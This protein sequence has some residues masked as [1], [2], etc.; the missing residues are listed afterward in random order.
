[1]VKRQQ[2]LFRA[3]HLVCIQ[4]VGIPSLAQFQNRPTYDTTMTAGIRYRAELSGVVS[5]NGRSPF[6]MRSN[7]FGTVPWQ[8]PAGIGTVGVTGLWG[9][10]RQ[11]HKPYL[12]AGIEVV[13]NLNS[14]S[15][16]VLP[17][18]YVAVRLGHGELYIGRQKEIHGLV[19]T[20]LTSGSIAWSG[21]A[22]PITQIR[23]G[24]RDFAP[25]K[26]TKGLIAVNAFF[27]HGWFSDTDS[28]HNVMLHA[29]AVFVRVGK[30]T[31]KVRFY[32][33][34]NHFAQWGGYSKALADGPV[35]KFLSANGYLPSSLKAYKSVVWPIGQP[36]SDDQFSAIDTIN[37]IGNHLGSI[38]AG[39]DI[40][41]KNASLFLYSQHIFE[42]N[43]GLTFKNFPDGLFGVRWKAGVSN[44]GAV[45][46]LKQLTA[47]FITTRNRSGTKLP[48][49]RDDYFFHG[50]YLDGWTHQGAIIGTP[51]FTRTADLP[52]AL[53]KKSA[54]LSR[55]FAY[56][57]LPVNNNDVQSVHV[58]AYAVLFQ[59]VSA[60][61]LAT[62]SRYYEFDYSART[63]DQLSMSLE[64]T[65]LVLSGSV[66]MGLKLAYDTG[67]IFTGNLGGMLTIRKTGFLTQKPVNR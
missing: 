60:V 30:P 50:Q 44:S 9:N 14:A 65:N 18:A 48:Y 31:W 19:D 35:S 26:F 32:G 49:G 64:L 21:N 45:V 66:N 40:Q 22:V 38:D 37:Q 5:T 33:G 24:T 27:S 15:R 29:K 57:L 10:P 51:I 42:D 52:S 6:W 28:M 2:S 62:G 23:L 39:L 53:L 7:Q 63:Y 41:L 1:M 54:W 3:I 20:L 4:L 56:R 47:E 43:S 12:K 8:F 16:L 55:S 61:L 34:I 59:R 67:A 13:G 11:A 58:G 17:E 46:Q 36:G 25:L